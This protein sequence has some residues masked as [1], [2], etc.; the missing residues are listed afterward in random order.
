M[1][2]AFFVCPHDWGFVQVAFSALCCV[3]GVLLLVAYKRMPKAAS[4]GS[5]THQGREVTTG[6][7]VSAGLQ[8]SWVLEPT[9]N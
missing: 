4:P 6:V 3:F 7:V 5:I 2:P 1:W 9:E 8:P